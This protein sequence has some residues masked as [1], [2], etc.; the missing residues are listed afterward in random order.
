MT[1][2]ETALIALVASI[3]SGLVVKHFTGKGKVDC[4]DCEKRHEKDNED[5]ARMMRMLRSLITHSDMPPDKKEAILNDNGG[6][7]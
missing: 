2:L 5:H 4:E 6:P 7:K 1:F 3:A